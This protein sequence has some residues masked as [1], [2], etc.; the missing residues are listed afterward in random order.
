MFK[1]MGNI[2][3]YFN[4]AGRLLCSKIIEPEGIVYSF[5]C[6]DRIIY[7]R[8]DLKDGKMQRNFALYNIKHRFIR[9]IK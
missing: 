5:Y 9:E 7:K 2:H 3:A 4:R 1:G 6:G 8:M